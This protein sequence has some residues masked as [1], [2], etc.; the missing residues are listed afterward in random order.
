MKRRG[1]IGSVLSGL[2]LA[3]SANTARGA[4]EGATA[5]DQRVRVHSTTDLRIA[6]PL[7]DDFERRHPGLKVD[8]V[9]LGSVELHGRAQQRDADPAALPDVLWSSAIDLQIK[10]VNDGHAARHVSP[11]APQLPAWAIWKHE[12]YGTTYEP[13]GLA[14]NRERLA[15]QTIP[16][17]HA[18]LATL[19]RADPPRWRSRVATY[20]I[21]RAGLGFLLAAQDVMATPRSWDLV[22][23]I[24]ECRPSL[25][26]DTH[27][28]LVQVA[29]GNTLL[30]YNVLGSYTE[31]F[32]RQHR[33]V[34]VFYFEDYT[35]VASRVA[36]VCRT[37]PNPHGA[38]LWID[39]LL[40]S[41]GQTLLAQ[42]GLYAIRRDL[43]G[44]HSAVALAPRLGKAFRPIAL[45][46]GLLA[47]LDHS[48]HQAILQRWRQEIAPR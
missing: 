23:A 22:R 6:Q 21:E 37:A 41:E 17:T 28:M 15:E 7:I 39:H 29:A 44:P 43:T 26:A 31:A 30:A 5:R 42:G 20:D 13:V 34:D 18:A 40:S 47:H 19:L 12:A 32:A 24:G 9:E 2:S 45:A 1:A 46:P 10:L 8:Y 36:F 25:H 14:L 4:R 35:L 16:R 3:R 38:R 33:E 48:K 27:S 11:H